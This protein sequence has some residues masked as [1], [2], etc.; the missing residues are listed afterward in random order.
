MSYNL[1]FIDESE[2]MQRAIAAIFHDNPEFNVNLVKEPSSIYKAPKNSKPDII[3]LSYNTIDTELK[4]SITEIKT[5]GEFSDTPL[6]LLVPSDLSDKERETL[7]E[8]KTD[9]FI[10]RPFDKDTFISKVK[11][12]LTILNEDK[13]YENADNATF[14]ATDTKTN[15]KNTVSDTTYT[16]NAPDKI[17]DVSKF[18]VKNAHNVSTAQNSAASAISSQG[19]NNNDTNDG[20]SNENND[21]ESSELSQA[22]ENLFKDDAIFKE[23]QY[24]NKKDEPRSYSENSPHNI[25]TTEET[26]TKTPEE[27]SESESAEASETLEAAEIQEIRQITETPEAE[28]KIAGPFEFGTQTEQ[29]SKALSNEHSLSDFF[30]NEPSSVDEPS[31]VTNELSSFNEPFA[32]KKSAEPLWNIESSDTLENAE[33]LEE[34]FKEISEGEVVKAAA[35]ADFNEPLTGFNIALSEKKGELNLKILNEQNLADLD[36]Y[37][38]DSIEKTLNEIKPQIMEAVKNNL[39]DI[40]EKLVREEIEKIKQS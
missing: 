7:I 30:Q 20:K 21:L 27:K 8:L 11:K 36:S 22:F 13:N 19:A 6:L 39:P 15:K 4:K 37:L 34:T 2:S 38:K 12:S 40:I 33:E 31:A 24:L 26:T 16:S 25:E 28:T 32:L 3:V 9:G 1:I 23:F 5:S 10:Y 29:P 17:F 14:A 18:E 35:Q